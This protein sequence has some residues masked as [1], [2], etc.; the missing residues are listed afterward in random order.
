VTLDAWLAA[1]TAASSVPL[2][3]DD[4][5]VLIAIAALMLHK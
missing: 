3:V 4:S 5:G 1:S 2:K